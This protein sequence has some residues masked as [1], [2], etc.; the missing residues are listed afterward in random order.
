[1]F[2]RETPLKM[3]KERTKEERIIRIKYISFCFSK[4]YESIWFFT[5]KPQC[6]VIRFQFIQ[7]HLWAFYHGE[8]KTL[9]EPSLD[10]QI[11]S[12][13][14]MM[15]RSRSFTL[16]GSLTLTNLAAQSHGPKQV[17]SQGYLCQLSKA[18]AFRSKG[19]VNTIQVYYLM[20]Q[21]RKYSLKF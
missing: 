1:M 16:Q 21:L 9:M 13:M 10:F 14:Y 2:L 12:D 8:S 5:N 11:V 4:I 15:A 6:S 19:G 18:W 3:R 7:Y 20:D 17:A